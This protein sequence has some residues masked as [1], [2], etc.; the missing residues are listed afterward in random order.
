LLTSATTP[1]RAM[2][3][4][5]PTFWQD[6]PVFVTGGTGL[7]GG[8]VIRRLLKSGANVVALVRDRGPQSDL[9]QDQLV[10]QVTLVRGDVG[11]QAL[12][13]RVLGEYEIAR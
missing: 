3:E 9:I 5:N 11:D 7:V 6:R 2:I 10:E 13:E 12:L 1:R 8:W 4:N